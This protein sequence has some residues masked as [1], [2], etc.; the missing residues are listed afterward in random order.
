M[1]RGGV[2]GSDGA[3]AAAAASASAG[4]RDIF[5]VLVKTT[6]DVAGTY[7]GTAGTI[8][9]GANGAF[10]D[11]GGPH[12]T[13]TWDGIQEN[14]GPGLGI[15]SRFFLAEQSFAS[16]NGIY[17]LTVMGDAGTPPVFTR[18]EDPM[19]VGSLV[20]TIGGNSP[21]GIFYIPFN[22]GPISDDGEL[23]V[24]APK[25]ASNLIQTYGAGELLSLTG[26]T[27]A[28]SRVG[29][30]NLITHP[31]LVGRRSTSAP[32]AGDRGALV[33]DRIYL[34]PFTTQFLSFTRIGIATYGPGGGN[35]RFCVYRY[36]AALTTGAQ[37]TN[38]HAVNGDPRVVPASG[39]VEDDSSGG[40]LSADTYFAAIWADT[41]GAANSFARHAAADLL[42][43]GGA[44]D[45]V[46][47]MRGI[48]G[49]YSDHAFAD[50][51]PAIGDMTLVPI[52]DDGSAKVP[53]IY[54]GS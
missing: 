38:V 4:T 51:W 14:V 44:V 36:S 21:G 10:D 9:L 42:G 8:T 26:N 45:N 18:I 34:V 23:A 43:F 53:A 31:T 35:V 52:V 29:A 12:N 47:D 46:T 37:P 32:Q 54:L 11:A 25:G 16:E 40:S 2:A 13:G 39:V 6:A 22:G 20:T 49:F 1:G 5:S 3:A 48:V 17:E 27:F 50:Q 19:Y 28:G 33:A 30:P 24:A 41:D 15:G 7:D